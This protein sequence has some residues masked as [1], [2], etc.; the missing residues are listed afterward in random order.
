MSERGNCQKSRFLPS[1][2]LVVGLVGRPKGLDQLPGMLPQVPSPQLAPTV[3]QLCLPGYGIR[4]VH[5]PSLRCSPAAWTCRSPA[6]SLHRKP[7]ASVGKIP[8]PNGC[9]LACFSI[10]Q[11]SLCCPLALR[12]SAT[13]Q[14]APPHSPLRMSRPAARTKSLLSPVTSSYYFLFSSL[15]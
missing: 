4:P 3:S 8:D 10:P 15:L 11:H 12:G 13:L 7:R 1:P 2:A 6:G 14:A 5:T 9:L